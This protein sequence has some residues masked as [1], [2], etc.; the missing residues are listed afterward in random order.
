MEALS[1]CLSGWC[2]VIVFN[3]R[4]GDGCGGVC[5]LDFS[6]SSFIQRLCVYIDLEIGEWAVE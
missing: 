6:P 2:E 1:A 5:F 4:R 3:E